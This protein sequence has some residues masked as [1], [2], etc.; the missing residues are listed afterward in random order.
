MSGLIGQCAKC[1]GNLTSGHRC[2]PALATS[3]LAAP[4]GSAYVE[5]WIISPAMKLRYEKYIEPKLTPRQRKLVKQLA[6]E[7]QKR[8]GITAPNDQAHA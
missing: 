1:G 7:I 4:S 6:S 5:T 2:S 3:E 8:L